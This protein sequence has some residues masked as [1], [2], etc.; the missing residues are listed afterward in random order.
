M[1]VGILAG[2]LGTRLSEETVVKPKPMVEIGGKPILWHIMRTFADYGFNEF[3]V[4]LGYKGE[5]IKDYFLNYRRRN[6]SLTVRLATGDLLVHNGHP[7]DW[8]VHLLDTGAKTQTGGRVKRIA[9]FIGRESFL[10][11]YG[12]GVSN[13]D[14][15]K[16]VQFHRSH[17]KIA[18]ITAVRPPARFG[19][20]AFNGE[21]VACFSEKPQTGE[22]WI[23]GGFF[24]LE[25]E[26][27]NYIDSDDVSFESLPM[28]RLT[29]D[30]QLMAYRHHDF[31]QCMDTLRDV[32][33]LEN[34]WLSGNVPW[35]L[36]A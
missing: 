23:N 32:Q 27:V 14:L 35:R 7:E 11:T 33:H 22:G 30:D 18:T 2:G 4:A 13:V 6:C 25:P 5:I 31:W 9:Q 34:M 17:G 3:V 10:L 8:T 15:E 21:K 16:L 28:E 24:V 1:K 12:D 36:H 19:D 29:R 26:I 20:L